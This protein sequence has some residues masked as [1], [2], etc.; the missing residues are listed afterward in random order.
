M[1][2]RQCM[3]HLPT[4]AA[5][6]PRC[7]MKVR[8]SGGSFLKAMA[9]LMFV[10]MVGI[11]LLLFVV[12]ST[13]STGGTIQVRPIGEYPSTVQMAPRISSSKPPTVTFPQAPT[14]SPKWTPI[15]PSHQSWPKSPSNDGL[16]VRTT[17]R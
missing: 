17:G 5:F 9:G 10:G 1:T 6:C 7:G 4:T 13:S 15:E 8:R 14:V 16:E 2:C 11:F 12:R 3:R